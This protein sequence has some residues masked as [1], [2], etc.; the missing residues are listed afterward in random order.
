MSDTPPR[1]QP[2]PENRG[3]ST[4]SADTIKAIISFLLVRSDKVNGEMV[5][6]RGAQSEAAKHFGL[7]TSNISRYW[8]QAKK[9]YNNP[10]IQAYRASPLKRGK[11]EGEGQRWDREEVAD[12]IRGLR[13]HE[14]RTIRAIASA[15]GIPPTTI[16][17]MYRNDNIIRR[18]TNDIKPTLNDY[19]MLVRVMYAFNRVM[20]GRNTMGRLS[21]NPSELTVHVDEKWFFLTQKQLAIYLVQGEEEPERHVQNKSHIVKVMFLTAV[22][23]PRFDETGNCTFDGKIGMWPFVRR[24]PAQR[25]SRNRARGTIITTPINVTY[26]VYKDFF[27][28]K[29]IPAIKTKF[30]RE[31]NPN[32]TIAIQHDNA[33]S[34]FRE[35]DPAW[36]AMV[37]TEVNWRFKLDEQP[38]NSPDTNVLDLGFFASIQT[39]QWGLEPATTIDGLIANVIR[40]WENYPARTLDRVWLTHMSC[41]NE[42]VECYGGNFYKIPHLGKTNLVDAVGNLPKAIAVSDAAEEVFASLGWMDNEIHDEEYNV[43]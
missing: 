43:E 1:N 23:R 2:V 37:N 4:T 5:P 21:Y 18:V 26:D 41:L 28:E 38:A 34:H 15:T 16:H 12:L 27:F 36:I 42:I 30:P 20:P 17:R 24:A 14:R 13:A 7:A 31:H 39:M 35:D 6:A 40:A 3:G 9:N 22:A 29:V 8:N 11:K 33:P 10:T 25:A 19:N 32:I